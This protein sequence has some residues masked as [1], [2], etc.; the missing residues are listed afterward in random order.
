MSDNLIDRDSATLNDYDHRILA[1]VANSLENGR[2]LRAWWERTNAAGTYENKFSTAQTLNRP[3]KSFAFLDHATLNGKKVP[4]MGDMQEM[5]Y[6][7][8]KMSPDEPLS[9]KLAAVESTRAQL[10]E[11][12]LRYYAR[13]SSSALPKYFDPTAPTPPDILNP[14]GLCPRKEGDRAG[15]GQK[16]LYYKTLEGRIGK[17][18]K[19]EQEAIIDFRDIGTKYE[20]MVGDARMF[21]FQFSVMPF[22]PNMPYGEWPL[23]ESQL[24]VI[25]QDFITNKTYAPDSEVAGEYGYGLATLKIPVDKTLVGFGPGFFDFGFMTYTWQITSGGTIRANMVFCVNQPDVVINPALNPIAYGIRAVDQFTG[26][27]ATAAL[28][29]LPQ[30]LRSLVDPVFASVAAANLATLGLAGRELNV[31]Q[32]G[33]MK[34]F[35]YYHY[36]VIYMLVANSVMTWRQIPDWLDADNLPDWVKKGT[37]GLRF[38]RSPLATIQKPVEQFSEPPH[39]TIVTT[40]A[41]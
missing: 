24:A 21:G 26:G 12:I 17:F 27:M 15:F 23:D 29:R 37:G 30:T 16:Q 32:T 35:L 25:S 4:V 19:Q 31:S 11:Y 22:G 7:N 36:I 18:H 9:A 3:D 33:V 38:S 2:Q 13:T 1:E 40:S 20:W 34:L 39:L 6:D 41:I 8:V 10:Q 14:L 28:D 5:F